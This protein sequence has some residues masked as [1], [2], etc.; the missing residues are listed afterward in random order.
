MLH[1]NDFAN[2]PEDEKIKEL[3]TVARFVTLNGVSKEDMH[4]LIRFARERIQQPNAVWTPCDK[5]LPDYGV[6]CNVTVS[7]DMGDGASDVFVPTFAMH[8]NGIDWYDEDGY[9]Y[10]HFKVLAWQPLPEPHNPNKAQ[11]A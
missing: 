6:K 8:Y 3:N 5:G 9:D 2:W 11:E 7:V 1:Y 10:D 4:E